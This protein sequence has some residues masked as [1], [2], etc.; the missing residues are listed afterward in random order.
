M[1][2]LYPLKDDIGRITLVNVM[3]TELD[4]VN[5]ARV[6]YDN[7]KEELDDKDIKLIK[8]LIRNHHT[9]PLRGIV[10]KFEVVAPLFVC[11]QWWKHTVASTYIDSQNQWNEVSYRYV[12]LEEPQFYIPEQFRKPSKV[13]K[14]ASELVLDYLDNQAARV[15]MLSVYHDLYV[16]YKYLLNRGVCREQAR[17]VLPMGT[18]TRFRW[19]CSLHAV[20][21]FLSLRDKP[22]AQWEIQQY[23]NAIREL[24]KN[25]FP[26]VMEVYNNVH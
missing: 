25:Y 12:E 6:S 14:Q 20:L 15:E 11:R 16:S 7:T 26:N 1:E 5:D 21:H 17:S 8:Y 3:G 18:Y 24:L 9:S 2:T 19:T 10:C 13:N 23:A 4:I 22:S